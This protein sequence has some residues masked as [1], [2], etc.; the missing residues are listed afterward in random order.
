MS[1]RDM[2]SKPAVRVE[3]PGEDEVI[4][5][6]SYTFHVAA[7]PGTVGVEVSIDRGAWMSCREALGLWWY[8][9]SA[10][11][12]GEHELAARARMSDGAAADSAPRRFFAD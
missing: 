4:S 5:R 10:L 12:K 8:D 9:A 11:E 7:S 6:K 3:Y 1:N 2:P